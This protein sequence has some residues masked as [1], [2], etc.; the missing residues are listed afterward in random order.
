MGKIY[1][2]VDCNSFYASCEKVFRPDLKNKPV[3]VL[4]N[5]D[6]CIVAMS[7]EAKKLGIKRGKP[8]FQI[9]EIIEKNNVEV[10]SSNYTLYAD[11]SNRVMST[12]REFTPN[13]EIYSIDEAFLDLSGFS[14]LDINEYC[15]NIKR[16]VEKTTGI[17]VSIGIAETKTLS[18]I[19]NEIAKKFKGYNGVFNIIGN[20]NR[21]KI[22]NYF[23]VSDVWGIG[24]QLSKKLWGFEIN[25]I[26][27]LIKKDDAWIQKQMSIKGVSTVR[28]LRGVDCIE[29]DE[30][31]K[32]K[33]NILSTRSF[34][35]PVEDFISMSEAVAYHCTIAGSKIRKQNSVCSHTMVFITTNYFKEDEPQYSNSI[36]IPLKNQSA[37][38]PDLIEAADC[39]LKN[40]Y[41]SG[42]K[43]KKTGVMLI[44]IVPDSS[45]QLELFSD[46]KKIE[47][48]KNL[49]K[50]IDQI[51]IKH[52]KE[53]LHSAA[54]FCHKSWGMKR[55]H[56]SPEYTTRWADLPRVKD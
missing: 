23:N 8:I 42:Y 39:G 32:D 55:D 37:Y 1:A 52:G 27:D 53:S 16:T 56:L 2:L 9:K 25:T 15:K 28:E 44:G 20:S 21:D 47:N 33:K 17:P 6:G 18:K 4:S 38:L 54:F 41:K 13:L 14:H 34:G 11:L 3:V 7:A 45:I 12:L 36:T 46:N 49:M 22:F 50:I 43:Y 31:I 5:N 24:G 26:A 51:N 10:F 19:A 48:N 40:I 29:L 35:T 30:K